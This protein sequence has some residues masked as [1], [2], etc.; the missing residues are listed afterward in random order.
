MTEL[1]RFALCV[2]Y[3]PTLH[4]S[5]FSD[6]TH[7]ST[8]IFTQVRTALKDARLSTPSL[9]L[10][11]RTDRG[12][13]AIHQVIA[14]D[15]SRPAI[16]SEINAHLPKEIRVFGV[17]RVPLSF[18]PRQDAS[19]R[20]Y[21]YFLT[22]KKDN[23][24]LKFQTILQGFQGSHNFQNFAKKDSK[25]PHLNYLRTIEHAEIKSV[26]NFTYQL[27]LS[28]KSFLWQQVRR[29]VG[30]LLEVINDKRDETDIAVLFDPDSFPH[31][32]SKRKPPPAPPE[33]LILEYIQYEPQIRFHY[34]Q[35][36]LREFQETLTNRL[37]DSRSNAALYQFTLEALGANKQLGKAQP[38]TLKKHIINEDLLRH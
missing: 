33:Y 8:N 27:R 17:A 31:T 1:T 13:G 35:R 12:V 24:L 9:Q 6:Q 36:S 11:S 38:Q 19:L 16:L 15:A 20:T 5:G 29:M 3:L 22:T 10:A 37:I 34:D 18:D 30:F 21:S 7:D 28:S 23:A 2:G 14:L 25:R 4:Y 26:T 32:H